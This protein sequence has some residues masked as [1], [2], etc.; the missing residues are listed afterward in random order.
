MTPRGLAMLRDELERLEKERT[1]AQ[2]QFTDENERTRQLALLNGQIAA[3][4]QRIAT[5]KV[6]NMQDHPL[7]EVRFGA[8]I[9]LSSHG[10]GKADKQLTIVGVDEADVIHGRIAFPAP[11]ARLLLGRKIGDLITLRT[12]QGENVLEIKSIS[13]ND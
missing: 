6:V 8:T 5:A 12:P 4:N 1:L 13:Y 7:D 11:I 2:T 3:L 9:T 10:T